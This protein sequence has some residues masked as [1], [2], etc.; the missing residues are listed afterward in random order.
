MQRIL[1]YVLNTKNSWYIIEKQLFIGRTEWILKTNQKDYHIYGLQVGYAGDPGNIIKTDIKS[2]K[3]F[4]GKIIK[5][6]EKA[7][8]NPDII[9]AAPPLMLS[10]SEVSATSPIIEC[11]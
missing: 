11:K 5:F 8:V 1:R 3:Q 9:W 6:S 4:R 10:T 7:N 2:I